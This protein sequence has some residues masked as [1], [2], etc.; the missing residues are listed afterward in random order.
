MFLWQVAA[1][2]YEKHY[3]NQVVQMYMIFMKHLEVML[4]VFV[5]CQFCYIDVSTNYSLFSC[6]QG[7]LPFNINIPE[8]YSAGSNE[9]QASLLRA[10]ILYFTVTFRGNA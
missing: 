5:F 8:A 6:L 4:L 9:E 2:K 3:R 1:L 10:N 7:M